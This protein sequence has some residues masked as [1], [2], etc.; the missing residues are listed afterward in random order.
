MPADLET[1]GPA[2]AGPL[3]FR[4]FENGLPMK[5]YPHLAILLLVTAWLPEQTCAMEPSMQ[6]ALDRPIASH[7]KQGMFL[8]WGQYDQFDPKLDFMNFRTK[9]GTSSTIDRSTTSTAN[10]AY[11]V[12]N[13]LRLR[14]GYTFAT[15]DATRQVAPRS[16]HTTYTGHDLRLQQTLYDHFPLL[17]TVEGGYRRHQSNRASFNRYFVGSNLLG[18]SVI[19][20]SIG[21]LFYDS[22][23]GEAFTT[24]GS[25]LATIKTEDSAW[26]GALRTLYQPWESVHVGFSIELRR[27]RVKASMTLPALDTVI[28]Q[29]FGGVVSSIQNKLNEEVPQS[30]PWHETHILL[31]AS[32]N[33]QPWERITLGADLTHYQIR[34]S[35]YIPSPKRPTQYNSAEQL[36]GYIFWQAFKHLTL[37]G[38]GRASTRYLLGDLPLAYNSRSNHRFGNPY[39][40]LSAGGVVSF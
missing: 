25:P 17:I 32:L 39:G 11:A 37:Y 6:R 27:V 22:A 12:T 15:Q 4:C 34:R 7:A 36:D 13:G 29:G 24:D 35:G 26:L 33:W 28:S 8:L 18:T 2:I 19:N 30:T 3:L 9:T 10:I 21:S 20:A 23:S 1:R 31:Q 5:I 14:Y 38:H 40:F 16:I